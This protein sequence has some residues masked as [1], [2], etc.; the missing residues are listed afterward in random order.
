MSK[1]STDTFYQDLEVGHWAENTFSDFLLKKGYYVSNTQD[2]GKYSPYDIKV[3]E[4]PECEA[5]TVEVKYDRDSKTYGNIA[6]ELYKV[7]DKGYFQFSGLSASHAESYVYKLPDDI[8]YYFISTQKLME[9]VDKGLYVRTT[10]GGDG[11]RTMLALFKK[12]VFISYCTILTPDD[13]FPPFKT[14]QND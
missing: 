13:Y 3:S 4:C 5:H 12:E 10:L 8:N 6:V 9:L 1:N 2:K 7:N 14:S 11:K